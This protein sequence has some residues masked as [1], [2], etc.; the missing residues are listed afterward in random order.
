MPIYEYRCKSC[1]HTFEAFQKLG[2]DGRD[3]NCPVCAAA[4]PE[5]LF[6]ISA[7]PLKGGSAGY[8]AGNAGCGSGGFS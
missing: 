7:A 6:S 2:A 5:K 1:G 8:S 4:A 3:L